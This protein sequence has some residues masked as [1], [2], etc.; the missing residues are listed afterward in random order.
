[1]S[2]QTDQTAAVLHGPRDLR[3]E[4][5]PVPDAPGPGE[6]S[7]RVNAV[8]VCGSDLH[9]Y[10]DGRIGE[11]AL[12]GPTV[13]GHEFGGTVETVGPDALDGEGRP[14][15]EGVRVAVDP[16]VPCRRCELCLTGHPNLCPNHTFIGGLPAAGALRQRMTVPAFCCFPLPDSIPDE[17]VPLLETLGV[18]LHAVDLAHIRVGSSVAVIG[19]GSV[20]LCIARVAGLAGALPLFV[21]DRHRWRLDAAAT[22]GAVPID[23]DNG[24]PVEAVMHATNGRGVDVAI[25]AAWSSPESL[26]QAVGVLRPGG[27]L[28]VV[29]I[30]G[31]DTLH[32]PH[33]PAR[34]K[35]LTIAMCRRM[36]HVTPRAI[37]LAAAGRVDLAPLVTHRFPLDQ[38]A[39]AFETA[40]GYRDGVIKAVVR[41]D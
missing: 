40:A 17:Q 19:A 39:E 16:A 35:G 20:G 6:V 11:T 32:F 38:T 24:D 36:K 14:L 23:I 7:I 8:G 3:I 31:D 33:S 28:V 4:R 25:E 1:M 5:Y 2:E 10:E 34:R 37:A 27:R 18:A 9:M 21:T 13:L 41:C 12:A 22:S 29:G 30:S 26:A 15:R